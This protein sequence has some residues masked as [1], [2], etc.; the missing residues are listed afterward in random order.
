VLIVATAE[1]AP[2]N[3]L[4]AVRA[5]LD[6]RRDTGVPLTLSG[7]S[8]RDVDIAVVVDPDQLQTTQT[9]HDPALSGE[10]RRR[11]ESFTPNSGA[12]AGDHSQRR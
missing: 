5:F 8:P 9:R 1:G 12:G 10:I 3:P 7:P 4:S 11:G 6:A 2:P